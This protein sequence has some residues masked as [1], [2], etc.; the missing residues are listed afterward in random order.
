MMEP[1]VVGPG[2][3]RG[4]EEILLAKGIRERRKGTAKVVE[5]GTGGGMGIGVG[6]GVVEQ[7]N[8]MAMM[9]MVKV[10]VREEWWR[11]G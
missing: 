3:T 11:E 9:V 4:E 7:L 1:V 5:V 6:K 2:R 10:L 8:S